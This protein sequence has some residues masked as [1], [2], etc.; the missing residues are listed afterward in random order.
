MSALQRLWWSCGISC[1][2]ASAFLRGP[3][4]RE[5]PRPSLALIKPT[6][7]SNP[8]Y[9]VL[10]NY[11]PPWP[12]ARQGA[13]AG[14]CL[15]ALAL[16]SPAP[17]P[18]V[19]AGATTGRRRRAEG[20]GRGRRQQPAAS[21]SLLVA[22]RPAG[23]QLVVFPAAARSP[24]S[25]QQ[26]A[27]AAR[28]GQTPNT[29]ARRRRR[30]RRSRSRSRR[31][32][33]RRRRG[34]RLPRVGTTPIRLGACRRHIFQRFPKAGAE[35]VSEPACTAAQRQCPRKKPS[36]FMATIALVAHS[37]TVRIS[38]SSSCATIAPSAR[39]LRCTKR[40]A[41]GRGRGRAR[42]GHNNNPCSWLSKKNFEHFF[43]ANSP[44]AGLVYCHWP[45]PLHWLA[46]AGPFR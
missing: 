11:K 38:W 29:K 22:T 15:L 1:P 8:R 26:P 9:P 39:R 14:A 21:R 31:G 3:L 44:F 34:G 25:P 2:G 19:A 41:H 13:G 27:A 40:A 33:R 10:P 23:W 42:T 45:M 28:R 43:D 46:A 37:R 12:D 35:G 30:R 16:Q 17:A 20:A 24:R 18:A 6:Q 36:N 4:P 32:R 5:T 7:I